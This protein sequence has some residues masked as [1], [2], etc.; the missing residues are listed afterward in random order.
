MD[1]TAIKAARTATGLTQA[2]FAE[3][4]QLP[5]ATLRDW[6]QGRV[7]PDRA[8]ANYLRL[9]ARDPAIVAAM[10]ATA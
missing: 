10:I 1:S 7:S 5:V 9:I 8:A 4:Y 6:E 3:R 2:A